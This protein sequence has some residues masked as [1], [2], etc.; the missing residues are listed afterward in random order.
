MS[1]LKIIKVY[2]RPHGGTTDFEEPLILRKGVDIG[3]VCDKLHRNFRSEFRFARVWGTSA[4][5]PGQKVSI[6][7][8]LHDEDVLTIVRPER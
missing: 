7:H 6:T 5:H 2:L 8:T 4:K 3:E 1:K